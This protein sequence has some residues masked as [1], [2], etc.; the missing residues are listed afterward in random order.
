MEPNPTSPPSGGTDWTPPASAILGAWSSPWL[1]QALA[2]LFFAVIVAQAFPRVLGPWQKSVE[3]IIS[4]RRRVRAAGRNADIDELRAQVDNLQQ[5]LDATRTD[6]RELLRDK[7]QH[8]S[9]L[10]THALWDQAMIAAVIKAGGTP[11]PPPTLW[12]NGWP[13]ADLAPQDP[14]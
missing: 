12:P 9:A 10:I 5:M 3:A 8:Y 2:V 7:D 1:I 6:V 14:H 13:G 11:P 4:A